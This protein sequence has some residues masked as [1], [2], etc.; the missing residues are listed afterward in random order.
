MPSGEAARPA[1]SPQVALDLAFDEAALFTLRSAVAAHA[2][3]LGAG[4][5]L[6]DVVLVA[7]ELSS[8][9]VRHGGGRG[10]LRLWRAGEL[11]CCQVA[12]R[13]AGLSDPER[14]GTTRPSPSV[15]GG[16]GLW[17]ARQLAS[18]QIETGPSGTTITAAIAVARRPPA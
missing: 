6:A 9:A 17:I 16:R 7:H 18:V 3:E 8:N 5:A 15:P 10:T 2:A 1:S 11:L 12:D 13:G 14:A 4:Q